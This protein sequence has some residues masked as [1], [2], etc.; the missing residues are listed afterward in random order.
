MLA[1]R[2]SCR[3]FSLAGTRIVDD[4]WVA[5]ADQATMIRPTEAS[6]LAWIDP[7]QVPGLLPRA[8][9]SRICARRWDGGGSS[10]T[11]RARLDREPIEQEPGA[12]IVMSATVDPLEGHV[13]LDGRLSVF[14]GA[15][16][17]EAIPI[18]IERPMGSPDALAFDDQRWKARRDTGRRAQARGAGPARVRARDGPGRE[19]RQPDRKNDSFSCGIS[20]DVRVRRCRCWRCR[21]SFSS[22]GRSSSR[23]RRRCGRDSRPPD[24]AFSMHRRARCRSF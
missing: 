12:S 8:S 22:G 23:R 14:A 19:D 15:E 1:V 13:R 6:G 18:W 4:A 7:G 10:P 9:R 5:W 17:I 2:S 21:A 3:G 20:L 11:G 16:P 24:C